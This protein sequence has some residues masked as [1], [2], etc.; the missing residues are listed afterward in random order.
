LDPDLLR[1]DPAQNIRGGAAL[2]AQYARANGAA[3]PADEASWYSAV[4]AYSNASDPAIAADFADAVYATM[5][6]GASRTTADG[7]VVT[8]APGNVAPNRPAALAS[9]ERRHQPSGVECPN[10]LDCEFVPA[11]YVVNNPADLSDY[12]NYDLA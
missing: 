3:L 8:L 11:A 12:G 9:A 10:R 5:Q 7:Q 2:L 6:Q 4:A 1:R